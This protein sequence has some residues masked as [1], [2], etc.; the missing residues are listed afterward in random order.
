MQHQLQIEMGN[1]SNQQKAKEEAKAKDKTRKEKLAGY[2]YDS[3]KIILAGIVVGGLA[4]LYSKPEIEL[5]YYVIIAGTISTILL[6]W[7]GNKILK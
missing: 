5:N 6:A 2:F 4:P 3:S 7:I 1:F